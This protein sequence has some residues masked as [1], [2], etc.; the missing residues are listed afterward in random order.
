[1]TSVLGAI[2]DAI[3]HRRYDLVV[4]SEILYYLD[5]A[6]LEATLS[7]LAAHT[8]P[9]TRIVAVHWRPPGPER[10]LPAGQVHAAVHRQSWLAPAAS[11]STP[12]YLLDAWERR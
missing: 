10:P 12:D 2:P 8:L 4:A 11:H 1:V 3:P 6:E 9:G 5:A 7:T